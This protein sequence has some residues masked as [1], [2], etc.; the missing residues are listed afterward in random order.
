MLAKA[1]VTHDITISTVGGTAL[2]F[3]RY[4]DGNQRRD[5]TIQDA[6]TIQ[7]ASPSLGEIRE[8]Q[9]PPE[10]SMVFSQ[11]DWR[12]GIGGENTET[13]PFQ[14]ATAV[15]IDTSVRGLLQNAREITA[16]TVD[17]NPD[18]FKAT[19]FAIVGTEFWAF[20]GRDVY[21]RSGATTLAIG[22]EPINAANIYRNGLEFGDY[23]I[24]ASWVA[25]TDLPTRFIHKRDADADWTLGAAGTGTQVNGAKYFAKG[26]NSAGADILWGGYVSRADATTGSNIIV[27]TSDITLPL[28]PANWSSEV[29]IGDSA[30]PITGLVSDGDNLLILKTDGIWAYY[31]DGTQENLTPDFEGMAHPDNFRGAYN[32]NGHV[33]LPMGAGGLMELVDGKLYDISM[34]ISAPDATA[35]GSS[36][37]QPALHGRVVAI[38]GDPQSL[39][40]LVQ[41]TTN[42]RYHLL[43]AKWLEMGDV[44]NYRWHHLG[45]TVYTTDTVEEHSALMA[46]GVPSGST[47]FRRI[48]IGVESTGSNLLPT[49]LPQETD[50]SEG[51]TNDTDA[52]A[53]FT[54][55]DAGRVQVSK[56]FASINIESAN[57]GAGGRLYEVEYRLNRTGSWLT[58]VT[59]TGGTVGG[60]TCDLSPNQTATF[61]AGTTGRILELR[62]KPALTTVGTT[63]PQILSIRVTSTLRPPATAMLPLS[64]HLGDGVRQLNGAFGGRPKLDLAQ[65]ITWDEQAAEVTVV[66]ERG[67]SRS[68]V[69]VAGNMKITELSNEAGMRPSYR[70]DIL[71][72]TV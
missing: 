32:W 65:L 22:T 19:G 70:V 51:F 35:V 56:T 45:W 2:G 39:F 21:S 38:T 43:M 53:Q 10:I 8:A 7:P 60:N 26:K 28:A 47:I 55:Y 72:A 15:K 30:A 37:T 16:V 12:G 48:W 66:D 63:G 34:L 59:F 61:P 6:P 57:L 68:M 71:L 36:A 69:F 64:L 13:H 17:T 5:Y 31:S 54:G 33:L 29:S 18:V 42:T 27:S 4:R 46:D 49:F 40:I 58:D 25:A 67:T 50:T 1:N 9:F 41:D 62:V 23:T 11:S 24:A 3:M 20:M 44:Y 52:V 14:L